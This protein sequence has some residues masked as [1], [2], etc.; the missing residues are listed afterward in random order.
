MKGE[1]VPALMSVTATGV[2]ANSVGMSPGAIRCQSE[3]PP[4]AG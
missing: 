4:A 3:G 2:V 1:S